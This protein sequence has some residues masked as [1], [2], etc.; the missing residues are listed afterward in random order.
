MKDKLTILMGTILFY[1]VCVLTVTSSWG[2]MPGQ[3]G[4]MVYGNEWINYDQTYLRIPVGE[5]G[6]YA[7]SYNDLKMAGWADE[8]LTGDAMILYHNGQQVPLSTPVE[9]SLKPG[10][11]LVFYGRK[12]RTDL[13]EFMF[14]NPERQVLNASYSL[15]T[16]TSVY[17][18]S[19]DPVS[20]K[21]RYQPG[22]VTDE[23]KPLTG[24][25]TKTEVVFHDGFYTQGTQGIIDPDFNDL[26]GFS[27][28][29]ANSVSRDIDLTGVTPIGDSIY[30]E[31]GVGADLN[32]KIFEL[33]VDD[34]LHG[35]FTNALTQ[36]ARK[37]EFS[38]PASEV[39]N[40]LNIT[41]HATEDNHRVALAYLR[42]FHQVDAGQLKSEYAGSFKIQDDGRAFGVQFE[43]S[44]PERTVF[45]LDRS[46]FF[47]SVSGD[48]KSY[49]L[50]ADSGDELVVQQDLISVQ[51]IRKVKFEN[52]LD[53]AFDYVIITSD[54]LMNLSGNEDPVA[55]YVAYRE[56]EAGGSFQVEVVT[57]EQLRDQYIYGIQGH[58]Y[59][60]RNFG[61]H[62]VE[63]QHGVRY[64]NI[65]GKGMGYGYLRTPA[66]YRKYYYHS[67]F[68]P[69]FGHY[70]SDNLL[71]AVKGQAVPRIPVGRIPVT[72]PEEITHYLEKVKRYE[73]VVQNPAQIEDRLWMKRVMHFNGGDRNI[74]S[75]ISNFMDKRGKE[76]ERDSFAA[77]M[78]SFYKSSFGSTDIPERDEIF[79]YINDGAALI[80]FFGH[81]ASSSLDFNIDIIEEYNNAGR[82][83]VFLALGCSSGN[84]FLP[85]KNL[86]ERF[87]LTPEVG[88]IL[89]LSTATSE[90]L[91]NLQ[92]LARAF[93][94]EFG[95]DQYGNPL[96][97][98]VQQSLSKLGRFQKHM[99][100]AF[101]FTGD[102]AIAAY[103]FEGPDFTFDDVSVRVTPERPSLVDDTFTLDVDIQNHGIRMTDT[104][105]VLIRQQLPNGELIT[106]DT[107]W[108]NVDGFDHTL[109]LTLPITEEMEGANT[110]F[111]TIDPDNTIEEHPTGVAE[112]NNQFVSEGRQGFQL[113]IQNTTLQ[114]IYPYDMAII[115]DKNPT[116]ELFNGHVENNVKKYYVEVDTTPH[117]SSPAYYSM[118][119]S[120][121][122]A[123][124]NLPV[125]QM[126]EEETVYYWRARYENDSVFT[127]YHS[128][129]Y[130]PDQTGWNQSHY[131]QFARDSLD[132]LSA[133]D[134]KLDFAQ[135]QN[136]YKLDHG[137]K[138]AAIIYNEIHRPR[139]FRT[140]Y[141][142]LN[143]SIFKPRQND[144]VRNPKP[145]VYN[146]I[147]PVAK[148]EYLFTFVYRPYSEIHRA[149][150]TELIENEA[151]EGDY[152]IFW[153]T[154][155]GR[156]SP[157]GD[158]WAQD[159]VSHQGVNL[160]NFFEKEGARQI[161]ALE[162]VDRR[163]Y[164]LIYQK[165]K[166]VV[167][168]ILGDSAGVNI[169]YVNLFSYVSEGKVWSDEVNLLQSL[170]R[171]ESGVSGT[172]GDSVA[173]NLHV[174]STSKELI[175]KDGSEV[176]SG[177][178]SDS[179]GTAFSWKGDFSDPESR[180]M[181][182]FYWRIFGAFYPDW[183]IT[184]SADQ[185]LVDTAALSD[186]QLSVHFELDVVGDP[187]A[188]SV[189]VMVELF[190]RSRRME[191][192]FYMDSDQWRQP[193]HR[194]WPL[195]PDYNGP[196]VLKVTI[197]PDQEWKES[198]E[199]NNVLFRNF[200]IRG[201]R[202]APTVEVL[203]DQQT[204]LHGDIIAPNALI[205][206]Q[207]SDY[208]NQNL[209]TSSDFRFEITK[210]SGN[211]LKIEAGDPRLS[212]R[213]SEKG[214]EL[215]YD[216]EFDENGM[217]ELRVSVRDLVGNSASSDYRIDFEVVL[218]NKVSAILPYPNPF[219]DAVR[220][221][222]TLTGS[223][224]P[225][226]FRIMIYTVS[227][228]LVKEITKAEFG[229]M[230]IGRH[231]SEF[232]WDGSDNWNQDLAPG[233]Y[234]Y[235]VI[236]R[237]S[238]GDD[239]EKYP[240]NALEEGNYFKNGIGKMVKLK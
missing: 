59:A 46:L 209:Q 190:N 112:Q 130:V 86:A 29:F 186:N 216:S 48:G 38:W 74:F 1:T 132:N 28:G 235:K 25:W 135:L 79:S 219:V 232:V 183:R 95:S 21:L 176:Q 177:S 170:D 169:E 188:D 73:S 60:I 56:S 224:E 157:K 179:E 220:F 47:K 165:G 127:A 154:T 26:E 70:G 63:V 149:S 82:L 142:A 147:W 78:V 81:S 49:E 102:P 91:T 13:E 240:I 233:V 203:F 214:L 222:Y 14:L 114:L 55:D 217:Y 50:L 105:A 90:Y 51:N 76:M 24:I 194:V 106:H 71:L 134:R 103:H 31:V 98:I 93:Y 201:D 120:S 196:A 84:I 230:R 167:T 64:V 184:N 65:I 68:V 189:L 54:S 45:N 140:T 96:G 85:Q 83:P 141:P 33:Y 172:S 227:G 108:T 61:A 202:I 41:V 199:K 89:F 77:N 5:D 178:F 22:Q 163:A 156:N 153:N 109:S 136:S 168:E 88:S 155:N 32:A 27:T 213:E 181:P 215:Q 237:D 3:E 146:S 37:I 128:F 16:D 234:L 107:A 185:P 15:F 122:Q 159:S 226:V 104:F 129:M 139:F 35:K 92:H 11:T 121:P 204:I 239:Y 229:P 4:G 44:S 57:I 111:L 192:R 10:D 8:D 150:I 42:V 12:N 34:Q 40:S 207:L 225:E 210:P 19:V 110:Y 212:I 162:K 30:L 116:L 125:Q 195:S 182:G 144:W 124:I 221:A 138:K 115:P 131:G 148:D 187:P 62:L 67:H 123:R 166:G 113:F 198:S 75:I 87:I 174:G 171:W 205:T 238:A 137:H 126:L 119:H 161:R 99:Q 175:F 20:T 193:V 133:Q 160:F 236:S 191:H 143:V 101:V 151:E 206:V 173:M 36:S 218:E 43:E 6:W 228:R 97:D 94:E 180:T 39:G 200:E 145:G 7:I 118:V 208:P 2:Q 66:N 72:D 152:V 164:S 9:G 211:I 18:L 69:T 23:V 158:T 100:S 197:D 17:F 231:L 53:R 58:P 223:D 117:F 80:S 52:Y